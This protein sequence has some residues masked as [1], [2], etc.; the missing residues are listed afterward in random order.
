MNL[1]RKIGLEDDNEDGDEDL[2]QAIKREKYAIQ[3]ATSLHEDDIPPL[4]PY[5]RRFGT[6]GGGR[7]HN[8]S[9][10]LTH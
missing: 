6:S 7:V 2:R 10:Q 8:V 9:D 4:R 3:K 5:C 1:K